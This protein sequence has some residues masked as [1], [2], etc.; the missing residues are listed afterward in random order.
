MGGLSSA[1]V[2]AA[3]AFHAAR[4]AARCLALLALL[5]PAVPLHAWEIE[6]GLKLPPPAVAAAVQAQR[7]EDPAAS[8][9]N[10]RWSLLS[11]SATGPRAQ[12]L[13]F[14][15]DR[16]QRAWLVDPS[17][18]VIAAVPRG[19]AATGQVGTRGLTLALPLAQDRAVWLAIESAL[20]VYPRVAIEDLAPFLAAERADWLFEAGLGAVLLALVLLSLAFHVSLRDRMYLVYASYLGLMLS[21]LWL[22]HPVAFRHAADLGLEPE[23]VA[24]LGVLAS[25]LAAWAAIELMRV[26]AGIAGRHSRAMR[27]LRTLAI[28]NVLLGVVDLATILAAPA[29]AHAVFTAINVLFGLSAIGSAALLLLAARDGS[30]MPWVFLAGWAP[31]VA[32]GAWFSLGPLLGVPQPDSPRHYILAACALQGL[33]WAAALADRALRLQRERDLAQ[34]MAENDPLT[35]LPNRRALD[36]ALGAAREGVVMLLDLDHFKAINDRFGHATGDACLQRF[37]EVLQVGRGGVATFGRYGGEEFIAIVAS[38]DVA[39]ARALAE[40][41]RM[42]TERLRLD[43]AGVR[44]ALTVSIGFAPIVDG[45]AAAL[46]AADRALYRAKASGRNRV[47]M[48]PG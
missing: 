37:A 32:F 35:G 10:V 19:S 21:A 40:R 29:F 34:A 8:R 43:R 14:A 12:F 16:G 45:A 6:R 42:D 17:G 24:A 15:R 39:A 28:A 44:V 48:E 7:A 11:P 18:T 41:L 47:E 31:L 22:R 4:F 30:R 25:A 26:A 36:R 38:P 5:L 27:L 46:A 33:I 2:M 23:R 3:D 9:R 20:G 1:V 13:V